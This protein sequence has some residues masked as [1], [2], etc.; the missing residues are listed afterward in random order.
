MKRVLRGIQDY[1]IF[2]S[3]LTDLLVLVISS[4]LLLYLAI[5]N[6]WRKLK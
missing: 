5:K 6:M 2:G 3:L 4:P 1:I